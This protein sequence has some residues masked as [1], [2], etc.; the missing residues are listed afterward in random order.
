MGHFFRKYRSLTSENF[1]NLKFRFHL[2][3]ILTSKSVFFRIQ[4]RI[5]LQLNFF[6]IFK[7][8]F[9]SAL[10]GFPWNDPSILF[11]H[12][13]KTSP[14][15]GDNPRL[16]HWGECS[17]YSIGESV[18]CRGGPFQF[19]FFNRFLLGFSFRWGWSHAL[20]VPGSAPILGPKMGY[21]AQMLRLVIFSS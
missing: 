13:M 2:L 12:I 7:M 9:S 11:R 3:K 18:P 15:G 8:L 4:L 17:L 10:W 21:F 16:I 1:W 19:F 6:E 5:Q 14:L 20:Q